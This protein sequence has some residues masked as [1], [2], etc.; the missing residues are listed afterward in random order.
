MALETKQYLTD[1]SGG[2]GGGN[3]NN[4]N[5]VD[6]KVKLRE[7]QIKQANNDRVNNYLDKMPEGVPLAKVPPKYKGDVQN[8]AFNKKSEIAKL[9]IAINNSEA[10]SPQNLQ[11]RKQVQE[12][13]GAFENLNNQMT[14]FHSYKDEYL[15]TSY[16]GNL[17]DANNPA[18][19]DLLGQVYTD[20]MNMIIDDSGNLVFANGEAGMVKFNDLPDYTVKDNAAAGEILNM[21]EQAFKSKAPL[22]KGQEQIYRLKLNKM[23]NN[24]DTVKSMAMDDF[25]MEGGLGL[26]REFIFDNSRSEELRETVVNSY[27]DMFKNTA[28]DSYNTNQSKGAFKGGTASS[29][30]YSARLDN[31]NTGWEA[32]GQGDPSVLNRTLSGNDELVPLE[33]EEGLYTYYNGSKQTVI[34]PNDPNDIQFILSGQNIPDDMWPKTNKPTYN[35]LI[36]KYK[37]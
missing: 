16:E 3:F 27:L 5:A 21:N 28:L 20:Q 18:K 30:K 1:L 14:N 11:Y 32:L 9:K 24:R 10:G 26:P 31:I 12:L 34:D 2:A 37:E 8:W 7:D 15:N 22:S 19:V 36:D 29:R 17:S 35:E 23:M 25:I 33:E 6:P 4:P 13:E